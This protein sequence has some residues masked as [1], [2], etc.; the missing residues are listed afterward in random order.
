[1]SAAQFSFLDLIMKSLSPRCG[2]ATLAL[3]NA[4]D[5]AKAKSCF[6][7]R[8]RVQ[9][10]FVSVYEFRIFGST[11]TLLEIQVFLDSFWFTNTFYQ[12]T[13]VVEVQGL[14]ISLIYIKKKHL[15]INKYESLT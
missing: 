12:F 4:A 5:L 11:N 8:Q 6:F 3:G 15:T 7:L 1:M 10:N 2:G 14:K 9:H 13:N